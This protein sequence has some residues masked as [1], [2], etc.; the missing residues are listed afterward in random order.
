MVKYSRIASPDSK[1][2]IKTILFAL[3]VVGVVAALGIR[4]ALLAGRLK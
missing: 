1:S 2:I 4:L 3:G